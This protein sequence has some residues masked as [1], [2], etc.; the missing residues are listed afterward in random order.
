MP[1][2][3]T[4]ILGGSAYIGTFI[5]CI[6]RILVLAVENL[7]FGCCFFFSKCYSKKC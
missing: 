3:R 7:G 6:N 1:S 5:P 4:R 2:V